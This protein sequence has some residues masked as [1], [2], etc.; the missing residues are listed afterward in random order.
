MRLIWKIYTPLVNSVAAR[1]AI[2]RR[3]NDTREPSTGTGIGKLSNKDKLSIIAAK[4]STNKENRNTQ[5]DKQTKHI[6]SCIVRQ[7]KGNSKKY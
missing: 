7:K 1:T 6:Y 5:K 2:P 3:L 4:Q